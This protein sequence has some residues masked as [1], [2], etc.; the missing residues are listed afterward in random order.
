MFGA[1]MGARVLLVAK[2]MEPV[3][4]DTGVIIMSHATF[5]TC[6]RDLTVLFAPGGTTGTTAAAQNPATIGFIADR[7]S[8]A[9]MSPACV[10]GR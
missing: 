7:G 4:S 1:L 8:R 2:T 3:T 6:P 5:E 9:P 10:Q